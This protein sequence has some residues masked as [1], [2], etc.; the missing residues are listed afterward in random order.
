M[1]AKG[2]RKR[3]TL[4]QQWIKPPLFS[5]AIMALPATSMGAEWTHVLEESHNYLYCSLQSR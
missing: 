1:I 5:T 3:I 2:L 4:M